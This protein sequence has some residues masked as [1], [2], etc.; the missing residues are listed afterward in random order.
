MS[1]AALSFG[2][3]VSVP[4]IKA[5]VLAE[6]SDF[7]PGNFRQDLSATTVNSGSRGNYLKGA[8]R[9]TDAGSEHDRLF[10]I[11]ERSD[12]HYV[13]YDPADHGV[14]ELYDAGGKV[15]RVRQITSADDLALE[16]TRQDLTKPASSA[17]P[18]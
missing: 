1:N 5:S 16:R 12:R 18:T 4:E 8:P 6:I 3:P 17:P 14:W 13:A 15:L 10:S 9:R 2:R 11:G 7:D